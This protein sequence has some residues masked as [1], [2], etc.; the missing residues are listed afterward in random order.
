MVAGMDEGIGQVIKKLRSTNL[1]ENTLIFFVSD[2]GGRL[3]HAINFPYRGHKGMLFEGGIRVPF[4]VS[5]PAK[6]TS[7]RR[8]DKPISALDIFPTC[9]AAAGVETEDAEKLDGVNLLPHLTGDKDSSPHQTLYWRYAVGPHDHGYA[10]RD[11]D[12]KLVKSSY[13]NRPML[14]DLE[15]DPWERDDLAAAKPS[16]VQRL[17][18]ML[19]QW[20]AD[21]VSP[22]WPDAHGPNVKKEEAAVQKAR[23]AAKRGER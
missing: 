6:L 14:F 18:T 17:D 21:N 9:V 23:A 19:S 7:T 20:D 3:P 13:K 10:I 4:L 12:W 2:N 22:L 5:W 11:G 15:K 1:F 8:Y 16:T